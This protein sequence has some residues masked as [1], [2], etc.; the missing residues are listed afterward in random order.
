MSDLVGNSDDRFSHDEAQISE[1][2][3]CLLTV[4]DLQIRSFVSN[5]KKITGSVLLSSSKNSK[6]MCKTGHAP[7]PP[8]PS[9][10]WSIIIYHIILISINHCVSF[11]TELMSGRCSPLMS[12]IPCSATAEIMGN[13]PAKTGSNPGGTTK[14]NPK[15]S[16]QTSWPAP[17]PPPPDKAKCVTVA[18]INLEQPKAKIRALTMEKIK[19]PDK[20]L[21]R[22]ILNSND[23]IIL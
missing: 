17:A 6:E 22:N 1:P 4:F 18:E 23:N 11:F 21:D 13:V 9:T 14:P 2:Y 7:P 8:P 10:G 12:Q 19:L 3:V 15:P 5:E 16:G 20:L